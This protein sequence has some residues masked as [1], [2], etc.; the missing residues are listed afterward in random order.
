MTSALKSESPR[1]TTV[2]PGLQ[3]HRNIGIMAHIDAGKTTVTERI[4][5][6]TEKIHRTGE[7]HDGAATMD[8]L[9]EEQKRGITISPPRPR[10][11]EWNGHCRSTSSTRRVTSTSPSRWSARCACSTERSPCSTRSAGVEAQ[12]E[13]VWRQAN[14]Y[15]VP[16][17]CFINKMDRVGADFDKRR[18]LDPS[19]AW[20]RARFRSRCRSVPRRTTAGFIDLDSDEAPGHLRPRTMP[21]SRVPTRSPTSPPS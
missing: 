20:T 15:G 21:R 2:K 18:R 19:S 17:I 5:F 7:V 1:K 12:S 8:Y 13:T 10:S 11:C 3:S 6:L 14:R 4:L 16:R 9:E